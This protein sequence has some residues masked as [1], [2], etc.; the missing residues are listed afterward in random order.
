MNTSSSQNHASDVGRKASWVIRELGLPALVKVC[1][2]CGSDR[3]RPS[4]KFRTNANGKLLDV[5]LL[6]HCDRCGRTAKIP[7]HERINVRALDRERR[8][9]YENND[10]AAVRD[11]VVNTSLA[12]RAMY[13]LDWTGTWSLDSDAPF[14]TPEDPAPV[15]IAVRFELPV[16]IR[17]EKLLMLGF[18]LSR[19]RVSG[20]VA[21]GRVLLP[22][23]VNVDTR[24]RGDFTLTVTAGPPVTCASASRRPVLPS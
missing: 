11:V 8:M 16:P 15:N 14:Y 23:G 13:R 24:M 18:G 12:A 10:P 19:S 6:V 17:V 9:A 3:H 5:W 21:S 20:I 7:V 22:D 4:G 2:S 1:L